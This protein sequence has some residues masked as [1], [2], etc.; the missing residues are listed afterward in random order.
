MHKFTPDVLAAYRTALAGPKGA[1]LA[2][3]ADGLTVDGSYTLGEPELARLPRGVTVP[4]DREL[5]ARRTGLHA[6]YE[7]PVPGA[8]P[9]AGFVDWCLAV[10]QDLAPVNNW[11]LEL[12]GGRG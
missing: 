1:Q 11:L 8:L 6:M 4:A 7:G 10:F 12:T 2:A 5:L 9:S 3:L